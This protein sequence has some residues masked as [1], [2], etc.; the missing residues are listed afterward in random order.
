MKYLIQLI[1]NFLVSL[2]FCF[3]FL[4]TILIAGK[5]LQLDDMINSIKVFFL[6]TKQTAKIDTKTLAASAYSKQKEGMIYSVYLSYPKFGEQYGRIDIPALNVTS[7]LYW[8]DSDEIL[9]KGMGQYSGSKLPGEEG[10]ALIGGHT[11]PYFLN[12]NN[13]VIGDTIN[14]NTT[15]GQYTF[16]IKKIK[17]AKKN[18][19]EILDMLATQTS[20]IILY[21]CD[22]QEGISLTDKRHYLIAEKA[23]GPL[24]T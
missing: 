1:I 13:L 24:I 3:L 17:I 16:L 11:I 14:I 12:V 2:A 9:A 21:T 15:Y 19:K 7:P 10:Y 23:S 20:G 6:D 22:R 4:G 5:Y 18:D 8:G